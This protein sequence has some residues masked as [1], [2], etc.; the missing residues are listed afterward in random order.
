[1]PEFNFPGVVSK[2]ALD[3]FRTKDLR[4]GFNYKDVWGQ[5][6]AHAFTVAKATQLDVLD[7]IRGAVDDALANGKTFAQF[8]KDLTPTLQGKG[9]WGRKEQRDPKTGEMRDVQL[10]SPRRLKT[11]YRANMRSARAA[12][13]WQRVQRTKKT[14]PY[15]LYQLGPSKNHRPEHAAWQGL[16]LPADHPF[17]QTHYPPNG[18]GCKC[19]VR[20]ISKREYDRLNATG[21]YLTEAPPIKTKVWTNKRTGEQLQVPEGLDPSW[22]RNPGQDRVRVIRE[23]LMQKVTTVDQR[24]AKYSVNQVM[25]SNVL[26][27]WMRS[28]E[29]E[30][31]VGVLDRKIQQALESKSQ[32]VRLSVDTLD[33]QSRSHAELSVEHYRILPELLHG[34]ITIQQDKIRHLSFYQKVDEQWHK[35]VVKMAASGDKL[36]LVSF[37]KA[38]PREVRREMKSGK[39]LRSVSIK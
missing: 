4:V 9:W 28:P 26:N 32:V 15:L 8:K 25:K 3:Y 10:G 5:E 14:H 38:R 30:L 2:D 34:G 23:Q 35:A 36:Y 16:I 18:W 12:G 22:M 39:V 17:W 19:R 31:P 33:K 21:K 27:D 1:M 20:Q 24:F 11:I 37:H 7:D 13:Q 6:H 29:G